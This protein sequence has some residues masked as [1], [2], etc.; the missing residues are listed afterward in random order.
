MVGIAG[1]G[2]STLAR[3]IFSQHVHVSL[4]GIKRWSRA[5]QQKML[6]LYS[7]SPS[8]APS[9]GRKIEHVLMTEALDDGQNVVVDDTNLTREIRRR[10]VKLGR[11]YD[12]AINVVFFQNVSRAYEQ[13]RHRP[14]PLDDWILDDQRKKL[15]PPC[16]D[17]GFGYIQSIK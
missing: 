8:D 9:K 1:S 16:E 4:D 12:A 6:D 15:E 17:E 11:K 3:R 2:K 10:H 5:R 7:R 13:N 14:E